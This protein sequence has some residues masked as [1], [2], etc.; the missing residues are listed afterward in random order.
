MMTETKRKPGRPLGSTNKK[1][2]KANII[3]IDL[4]KQIPNAPTCRVNPQ[5]WVNWGMDNLF[6]NTITGLY[7]SSSTHK[8]CID[9]IVTAICGDSINAD[10][11]MPNYSESWESFI[12]KL[13]LDLTLFGGY[14]FQVIMNKDGKTYSFFHEPFT[15]VRCAPKNDDGQVD[16]LWVCR[17]WS[18]MAK[19]KPFI[20][21]R[22]GFT[23]DEKIEKGK[24]Y[25]FY[26][27]RYTV[28]SEY[29]PLPHYYAALKSIQTEA[30][31]VRYDLKSV[32]NNFSANGVVA[33][34]R[35]D[36]ETERKQ[37]IDSLQKMFTGSE[38]SN[39]VM[40]T[41][42]NNSEDNPV[43]FTPFDKD[44]SNVN[45]FADN[46]SRTQSRILSAHRI[47]N[48]TLIGLPNEGTGFA[49]EGA[50]L[51]VSFNLLNKTLINNMRR[52]ITSTINK[53]MQI[54][55][56]DKEIEI[57]PLSFN[58]SN[59]VDNVEKVEVDKSVEEYNNNNLEEMENG[60]N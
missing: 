15:N 10:N 12:E 32:L 26:Y 51:E 7:Y 3:T 19:N 35:I 42:K 54:N 23:E 27:S 56:V 59:L 52:E 18:E 17:D 4:E 36:D 48:P 11:L 33:L 39:T 16:Q 40:I 46:N 55:G 30:E 20:L 58:L 57:K 43:T 45:L 9:F 6:P 31:L 49:N 38:N 29:Y 8:S 28:D 24:A 41:F 2:P 60:N 53:M 44:I 22:F 13:A 5:G 47:A 14:A 1:T 50:L 34:D 37:V 21:P 25:L